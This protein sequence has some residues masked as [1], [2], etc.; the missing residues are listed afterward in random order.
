MVDS[1]DAAAESDGSKPAPK[2]DIAKTAVVVIHGMGEQRPLETLRDFVE[3]VYQ[4]DLDLATGGETEK[5][6]VSIVP[7]DATGSAELRRITTHGDGPKKRIDFFEF[8]WADIMTGTPLEMVTAWVQMLLF[9]EPWRV[10]KAKRVRRAW[11]I[12]WTLAAVVV[13]AAAVTIYPGTF[14]PGAIGDWIHP[15]RYGLAA[16]ATVAAL[17]E[18][19]RRFAA[20]AGKLE[21]VRLGLPVALVVIALVLGALPPPL[22][23]DIRF[24]A[25][26]LT[27]FVGWFM[28][29]LVAPYLGD[30]VRYVRATPQTIERRRQVRERGVALLEALHSKRMGGADNPDFT[31]ALA[32]AKPYYDRIVI[33][34]HSLG[35]V[36]AYDLL[37]HFWERYGPTHHVDWPA[38]NEDVQR[39]LDTADG[40][41]K[42]VWKDQNSAIDKAAFA[43]SQDAL[44]NE[45]GKSAPWWRISDLITLGCPLVHAEFLLTDSPAQL[46]LGFVERRFASAP[47]RP[48]PIAGDSMLYAPSDPKVRYPHFAA[49]FAAVRW[50]NIFD[51]ED[52]PLNGDLVSGKTPDVFGPGVIQHSV[53]IERPG[54]A[55]PF[56]RIFT[57]TEYWTWHPSY[58]EPK[59]NARVPK[60]IKHL[61]D[62]LRLEDQP[63]AP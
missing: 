27:A 25:G 49:Q 52:N 14:S 9:R 47:P 22:A 51:E 33:V 31:N 3:T 19:T 39:E 30:V 42:E 12:L 43:S 1:E 57:H 6:K 32:G 54:W 40:F 61:R 34:G 7:D 37:Q 23:T 44:R 56:R 2:A 41:V 45:L 35:S 63:A 62:A 26:A 28:N 13:F 38:N 24:W 29:A 5:L 15:V 46:G 59:P 21:D 4:R 10:P 53:K 20:A 17:V 18:F 36:I 50:I 8:Y 48:D 16:I 58:D 11:Y 55:T 60:H